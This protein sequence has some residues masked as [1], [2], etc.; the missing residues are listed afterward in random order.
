MQNT[1]LDW[2][3]FLNRQAISADDDAIQRAPKGKRILITGA[4]GYIGSALARQCA[5]LP[6]ESL[7]LLDSSEKSIYDLDSDL[8]EI[9]SKLPRACIVG[10]ICDQALLEETFALHHPNIVF[11]A[12]ACKHV[13]LM[14]K[15]PF[16]AARTNAIGTQQVAVTAARYSVDQFILLSTDKAVEPASI[17]GATKRI[18]ELI[19]LANTS[20]T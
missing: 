10:D 18:A 8:S 15:N 9:A 2:K 1:V 6:I 17:M 5:H 11:H 4:G 16:T 20:R 12:A 19:V 3:Q 13:P 7:V 14:E